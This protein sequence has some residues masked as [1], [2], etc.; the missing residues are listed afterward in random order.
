MKGGDELF[1][2]YGEI[3][4]RSSSIPFLKG[5]SYDSIPLELQC[6][7]ESEECLRTPGFPSRRDKAQ[8][9]FLFPQY[10]GR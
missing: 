1:K 2:A 4:G 5:A 7:R 6:K 3:R 9:G 10:R 8:T